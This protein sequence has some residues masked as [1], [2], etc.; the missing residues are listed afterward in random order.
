M[1]SVKW[2]QQWE[3]ETFEPQTWWLALVAQL[4]PTICDPMDLS[5][6]GSSVHGIFQAGILE[7]VAISFSR[8]TSW[9]RDRTWVSYTAGRFFTIWAP[10]EARPSKGKLKTIL[11][12]PSQLLILLLRQLNTS[13]SSRLSLW[14]FPLRALTHFTLLF[15]QQ[16]SVAC[17]LWARSMMGAG[18]THWGKNGH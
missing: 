12:H 2:M 4:Y 14:T 9:P 13:A 7:W 3:A 11:A 17:L 18:I 16:L 5:P 1:F 15:I 10:R 6:P 8:G